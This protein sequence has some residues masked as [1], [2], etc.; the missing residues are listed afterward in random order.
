VRRSLNTRNFKAL[1]FLIIFTIQLC[2]C[3]SIPDHSA[4]PRGVSIDLLG[5][6]DSDAPFAWHPDGNGI[7]YVR[8]KLHVE[9]LSS[10]VRNK[11]ET[12][13]SSISW[14]PNG[15]RL[16]TASR[17]GND[18]KLRIINMKG[19]VLEETT[20]RGNSVKLAW[21]SESEI[22]AASL[23]VE[24]FKF[25]S[26]LRTILYKWIPGSS[27]VLT[28]LND[29]TM[30]PSRAKQR[31]NIYYKSFL[32]AVSPLGDEIAYTKLVE[33]PNFPSY[34]KLVVR[35]IDSG[36]EKDAPTIKLNPAGAVFSTDTENILYGDGIGAVRRLSPWTGIEQDVIATPGRTIALSSGDRYLYVDGRLYFEGQEIASFPAEC[37]AAF[38][39]TGGKI[40]LKCDNSL[41]ILSGLTDSYKKLPIPE[42][43][44]QIL[45]LRKWRSEGL[46]SE[47]EYQS[48]MKRITN[49]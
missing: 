2:G 21:I 15:D 44:D 14:S 32:F 17:D 43:M 39:P 16:V 18:T 41:S 29:V 1:L 34:L 26:N 24:R 37:E 31:E 47:Q 23:A 9:N 42:G 20:V 5:E 10:G 48:A 25:G 40:L 4:L 45:S 28:I 19:A 36:R 22:L 8:G 3:V 27:P 38:A 12:S 7:A 30:L 46:I 6:I 35:N 49:Q 11:I 33:P 13:P